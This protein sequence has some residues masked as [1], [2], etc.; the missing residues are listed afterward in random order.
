MVSRVTWNY[1]QPRSPLKVTPHDTRSPTTTPQVTHDHH[2]SPP[3]TTRSRST[4]PSHLRLFLGHPLPSQ[5]TTD[6]HLVTPDHPQ[7]TLTTTGH[8]RSHPRSRSTNHWSRPTSPWS[9][10]P[11][12][13]THD[14]PWSPSPPTGQEVKGG[15]GTRS[16][17]ELRQST[18]QNSPVSPTDRK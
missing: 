4:T 9:P 11:P 7:V 12:Q 14:Q 18:P 8:P 5:V 13:V 3:T 1:W 16:P 17:P 2:R 15:T 6:H 10:R